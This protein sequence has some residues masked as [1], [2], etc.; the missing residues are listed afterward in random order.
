MKRIIVFCILATCLFI[1]ALGQ[2]PEG[3]NYQGTLRNSTGDL[4]KNTSITIKVSLIEDHT[5]GLVLFSEQHS[6]TTSDY[7][8]FSIV[9]G[10]GSLLEGNFALIDWA[11]PM[12]IKTEVANPAGGAFTDM[13]T[14]QLISVPYALFAKNVLNKNDADADPANELQAISISND[15]IFLSNGGFVKLPIDLD[16][17]STNELQNLTLTGDTL[18]ISNGNKVV[19]PYDSSRWAKNGSKIY[20][21]A[22]NVGIGTTNPS[23]QLEIKSSATGALFQVINA[24]ND[25]VFA[26]Y[27]DGVKVFVDPTAK[28]SVGGFAVSGRSPGKAN[29]E[30]EYLRVTPD[31]TRIYVNDTV[32]TKGKVGGFAVSGRSPGKGVVNDYLHV[33]KDSTRVYITETGIKGKVGGFAVSGRSPGK[34]DKSTDYFNIS[35]NN[36]LDTIGSES[37]ILWY[38]KKE[39]FLT[40]R[41]LIESPDNVGTNS[42]STGFESKAMGDYSQAMGYK[43]IASGAYSTAIG[44][45]ALANDSNS[46]AFGN[47]AQALGKNSFAFG[48][49]AI[50]ESEDG[51]AI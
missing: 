34:M 10:K 20:Y 7:G 5:A 27:P 38:P 43:S 37:R 25:T 18:K 32:S 9:V 22:G 45:Q 44:Y 3:F 49:S 40:G 41:V 8:Q 35:G 26:V 11:Q 21:N 29:V 13:G 46:F 36:Q 6:V 50:V 2:V 15:S 31:S 12:F 24:N 17:S 42:M 14:V 39:A 48:D 51:Y 16:I 28:G 4:V 23:S 1:Q 19:F 33:T 30:V 47:Y